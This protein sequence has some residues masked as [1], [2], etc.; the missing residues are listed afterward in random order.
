[1]DKVCYATG[2]TA[3][4]AAY[5]EYERV[6]A[7]NLLE[8]STFRIPVRGSTLTLVKAGNDILASYPSEGS[9]AE[10]KAVAYFT[11]VGGFSSTLFTADVALSLLCGSKDITSTL[12]KRHNRGLSSERAVHA[13]LDQL[14]EVKLLQMIEKVSPTDKVFLTALSVYLGKATGLSDLGPNLVVP[15]V[16]VTL[17]KRSDDASM[18]WPPVVLSFLNTYASVCDDLVDD[19]F[20]LRGKALQPYL[21]E[22]LAYIDSLAGVKL[23]GNFVNGFVT[24]HLIRTKPKNLTYDSRVAW[25]ANVSSLLSAFIYKHF[26]RMITVS[27][28]SARPFVPLEGTDQ[29]HESNSYFS[30]VALTRGRSKHSSVVPEL[31]MCA[32][33]AVLDENLTVVENISEAACIIVLYYSIYGTNAV[34][35]N[36]RPGVL[37]VVLRGKSVAVKLT[38]VEA[39]LSERSRAMQI[40]AFRTLARG[41][42]ALTLTLRLRFNIHRNNWRTLCDI[43][44]RVAFDTVNFVPRSLVPGYLENDYH[45]AVAFIKSNEKRV[46]GE[47]Q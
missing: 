40:N 47:L 30:R 42:A 12:E 23:T 17:E 4:S 13:A 34:R 35:I 31:M 5:A 7:E 18:R 1:M 43:D 16:K 44:G 20:N 33:D 32:I 22:V 6:V 24:G 14:Q 15:L 46:E 21:V 2:L 8:Y 3:V 41:Y 9:T 11:L 39:V 36:R 27:V 19:A 45:K 38:R 29:L 28:T 37:P 10:R 25:F 26:G